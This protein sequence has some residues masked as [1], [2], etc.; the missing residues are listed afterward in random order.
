MTTYVM[1]DGDLVLKSAASRMAPAVARSDMPCPMI[2][3]DSMPETYSHATGRHYTSRRAYERDAEAAGC[4]LLGAGEAQ[5][6]AR[7]DGDD[8]IEADVA[9]AWDATGGVH[10]DD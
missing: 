6:I 3:G 10:Y 5:P 9:D 7:G 4:H 8:G 2:I 1:R